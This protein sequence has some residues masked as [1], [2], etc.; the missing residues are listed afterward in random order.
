MNNSNDIYALVGENFKRIRREY[1]GISQEK[2][3]EEANLSRSFISHL[4]S[5]YEQSIS[6]DTLFYLAKKY[7]F[8]IREFFDGYNEF[9][10]KK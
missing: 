9:V 3:A 1:L 7:N 5:N 8:D 6:I 4:E 10:N 2:L